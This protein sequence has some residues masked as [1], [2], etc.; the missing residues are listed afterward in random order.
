MSLTSLQR[1]FLF[2]SFLSRQ[3]E[4]RRNKGGWKRTVLQQE[5]KK[6]IVFQYAG[7]KARRSDRVYVWGCSAT[8]A[9][10]KTRCYIASLC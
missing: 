3:T 6:D 2:R 10:G 7:K 8:G 4:L 1:R 9:L 5:A